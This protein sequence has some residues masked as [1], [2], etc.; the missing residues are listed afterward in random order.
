MSE[1]APQPQRERGVVR[2]LGSVIV[3]MCY[4]YA[5]GRSRAEQTKLNH[6][7]AIHDALRIDGM[8]SDQTWID[9]R[10]L[11]LSRSR[12]LPPLL[13]FDPDSYARARLEDYCRHQTVLSD[14]RVAT[15]IPACGVERA[16]LMKLGIEVDV[17]EHEQIR[18]DNDANFTIVLPL[19][20]TFGPEYQGDAV[21]PIEPLA[22]TRRAG[23]FDESG[24]MAVG[25]YYSRKPYSGTD[26]GFTSYST[27][28]PA[29]DAP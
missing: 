6:W 18:Q 3:D 7:I 5:H 20:W 23:V 27:I 8:M 1:T 28:R 24:R 10:E 4:R 29:R 26:G 16:D 12:G 21:S 9:R 15:R 22:D 19:D 13:G 25:V 14:G 17:F 2:S 11:E